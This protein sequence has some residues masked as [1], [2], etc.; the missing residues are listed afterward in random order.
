MKSVYTSVDR[1]VVHLND[2]VT[3]LA[4]RLLSGSFHVINCFVDW[5]E[6]SQ[7][8]ESGLKDR[9]GTFA[10]TDLDCLVDSVDGI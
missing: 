7:F 5:H 10:H 4:V 2:S 6:V 1:F 3:L 9:V 8:E